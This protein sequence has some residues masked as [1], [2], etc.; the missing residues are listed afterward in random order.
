MYFQPGE[1]VKLKSG[2]P[3]MTVR[4]CNGDGSTLCDWFEDTTAKH[5]VFVA[6]QL[7]KPQAVDG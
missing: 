2:G 6:Q 4:W 1:V 5:Q 7:Q 3:L